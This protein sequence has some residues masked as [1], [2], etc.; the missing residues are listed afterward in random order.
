MCSGCVDVG[1][2]RPD[3]TDVV[4]WFCSSENLSA[5]TTNVSHSYDD[6]SPFSNPPSYDG[7]F[8]TQRGAQ[9]HVL[10]Y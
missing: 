8:F 6:T 4:F 5:G 2:E 9:V 7:G 3:K 10:L 1:I